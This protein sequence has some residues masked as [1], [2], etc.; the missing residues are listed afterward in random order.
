VKALQRG[1]FEVKRQ[2][3]DHVFLQRGSL[4]T[5]VPLHRE[6]DRGT[7]KAILNQTQL[8]TEQF[9]GLL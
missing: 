6:L 9:I 2:K 5:T 1:G 8:S 7:L 3:G 4:V